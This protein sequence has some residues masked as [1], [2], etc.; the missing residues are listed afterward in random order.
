MSDRFNLTALALR[1][2][3]LSWFFIAVV[4]I[5]GILSYSKLGQREDPD[6]TFRGMS[7]RVLWPGATTQQV[8]EQITARIVQKLQ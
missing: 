2:R 3:E 8:D 5:A 4:A 7:I 6:F 1:Q